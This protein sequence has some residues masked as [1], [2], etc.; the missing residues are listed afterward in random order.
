MI[1]SALCAGLV[2]NAAAAEEPNSLAQS[3]PERVGPFAR[4]AVRKNDASAQEGGRESATAKYMSGTSTIQWTGTQFAAP[5]QAVAALEQMIKSYEG[6][7]AGISS[8]KDVE[9]KIRY[10]VIKR[11]QRAIC[12]WVNKQRKDLFFVVMGQQ[13]EIETFMRSQTTW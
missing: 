13:P 5:E 8:V 6:E 11:P 2:A 12:C 1:A 9:G 7:G 3:F 4:V 10:A